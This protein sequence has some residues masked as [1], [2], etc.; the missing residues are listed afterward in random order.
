[1][2]WVIQPFYFGV[3]VVFDKGVHP[4]GETLMIIK[5]YLA[6]ADR[7]YSSHFERCVAAIKG[8]EIHSAKGKEVYVVV[9]ESSNDNEEAHI[10]DKLYSINHLKCLSLVGVWDDQFELPQDL[11][12][13]NISDKGL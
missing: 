9:T 4:F 7:K 8:C 10:L 12:A 6:F 1:M 5:S 3:T 11:N 13:E 2:T